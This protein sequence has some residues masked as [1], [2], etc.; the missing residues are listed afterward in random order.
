MF[1]DAFTAY[2]QLA[3]A[4]CLSYAVIETFK[5]GLDNIIFDRDNYTTSRAVFVY[6]KE[7]GMERYA[8][9]LSHS[10][11]DPLRQEIENI[12]ARHRVCFFLSFLACIFFIL[13]AGFERFYHLPL[14]NNE[15]HHRIFGLFFIPFVFVLILWIWIIYSGHVTKEIDIKNE[16]EKADGKM[17]TP[18]PKLLPFTLLLLLAIVLSVCG[19]LLFLQNT[20]AERFFSLVTCKFLIIACASFIFFPFI[21]QFYQ[22]HL[23]KER[24]SKQG[25]E[26]AK[27]KE[28]EMIKKNDT[29]LDI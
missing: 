15:T 17:T 1:W 20:S 2:F 3:G 19:I 26:Y 25:Y 5:A 21:S 14:Y 11:H 29:P 4:F 28:E 18:I 10:N 16:F 12:I 8:D 27:A 6:A 23:A 24:Y 13:I 22:M 7:K 9:Y